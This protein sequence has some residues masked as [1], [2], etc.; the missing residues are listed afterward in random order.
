[1]A[2]AGVCLALRGAPGADI[3]Q[4][5]SILDRMMSRSWRHPVSPCVQRAGTLWNAVADEP[6]KRV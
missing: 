4:T 3:C 6:E 1:M 2:G 5:M